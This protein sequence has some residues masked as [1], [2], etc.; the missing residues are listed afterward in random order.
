MKTKMLLAGILSCAVAGL[1]AGGQPTEGLVAHYSFSGNADDSGPNGLHGTVHGATL[2]PDRN[3]NPNAAYHFN[4]SGDY[5]DVGNSGLL[6]PVNEV[7]LSLWAYADWAN[8]DAPGALAGNTHTGGY[9]LYIDTYPHV[10]QGRA[11]RN[12][13]YL[14]ASHPLSSLAPG[15][16]HFAVVCDGLGTHLYV[17]GTRM[18]TTA[19]TGPIAY[20]YAN[21]FI[22]GGEAGSGALPEGDW[23]GGSIDEVRVYDRALSGSEIAALSDIPEVLP[24]IQAEAAVLLSWEI[25]PGNYRVESAPATGGPWGPVVGVVLQVEGR[26]QLAVAARPDQRYFRLVSVE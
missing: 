1:A 18:V 15:W 11:R 8:V 16:H 14:P 12:G 9:E 26:A 24:E 25:V 10:I 2:A 23:Y 17:N 13:A 21:G 20:S 6:R 19:Q 3:G 22:I 5:I 4:G 7:T